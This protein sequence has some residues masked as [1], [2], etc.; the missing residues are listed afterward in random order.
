MM[1]QNIFIKISKLALIELFH[2]T[3]FI[4]IIRMS[5]PIVM[6]LII[7]MLYTPLIRFIALYQYL[8]SNKTMHQICKYAFLLLLHVSIYF[9]DP[10]MKHLSEVSFNFRLVRSRLM[11]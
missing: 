5:Y 2:Y 10:E 11:K 9:R 7:N 8:T 1:T 6:P 4:S 3:H